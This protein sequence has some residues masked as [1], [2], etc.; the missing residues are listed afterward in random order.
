MEKD[1]GIIIFFPA[2]Y[3]YE[4]RS[5]RATLLFGI[6]PAHVEMQG[7]EWIRPVHNLDLLAGRF[8]K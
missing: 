8:Y 2:F 4:K 7:F 3:S 6:I 5:L 1:K